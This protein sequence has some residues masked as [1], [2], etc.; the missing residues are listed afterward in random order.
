MSTEAQSNTQAMRR[1]GWI[2]SGMVIAFMIADLATLLDPCPDVVRDLKLALD[3]AAKDS[4]LPR[5][6]STSRA[7][8]ATQADWACSMR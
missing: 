2:L 6:R 8:S 1:T 5:W 3:D 4:Q 7:Y